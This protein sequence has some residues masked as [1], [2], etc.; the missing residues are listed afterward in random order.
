MK[1][2]P[3]VVGAYYASSSEAARQS[4]EGR[5]KARRAADNDRMNQEHA[6]RKEVAN[7]MG[8]MGEI[9]QQAMEDD[10]VLKAEEE[11]G[12]LLFQVEVDEELDRMKEGLDGD[13]QATVPIPETPEAPRA[14]EEATE[15]VD[16]P[17]AAT[18]TRNED[19]TVDVQLSRDQLAAQGPLEKALHENKKLAGQLGETEYELRSLQEDFDNLYAKYTEVTPMTAAPAD[20]A[21]LEA[22][23]NLAMEIIASQALSAAHLIEIYDGERIDRAMS[24]LENRGAQTS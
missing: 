14:P 22:K 15:K 19:G 6:V 3:D 1:A 21:A 9:L 2:T 8:N 24:V 11:A 17:R 23:L 16:D 7:T 10:P 4:V 12:E 5:E 13:R 20:V 18:Y